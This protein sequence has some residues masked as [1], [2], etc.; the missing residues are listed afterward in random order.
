[1]ADVSPIITTD[2]QS[3]DIGKIEVR[4]EK[5][6]KRIAEAVLTVLEDDLMAYFDRK[7]IMLYVP[8]TSEVRES[9][10]IG[11][12]Q[13]RIKWST[14]SVDAIPPPGPEGEAST[15]D[16]YYELGENE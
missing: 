6:A 7:G 9:V 4:N 3:I 12:E 2:S 11:L 13:V 15:L 14:C 1:M 10:V 8:T 16:L 5:Q